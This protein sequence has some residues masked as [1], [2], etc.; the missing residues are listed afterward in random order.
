MKNEKQTNNMNKKTNIT[1]KK[2]HKHRCNPDALI[3]WFNEAP[4]VSQT[5]YAS[6]LDMYLEWSATDSCW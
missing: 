5:P 3:S 1:E 6:W 4:Y 2:K